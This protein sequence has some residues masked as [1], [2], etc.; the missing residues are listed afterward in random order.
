MVNQSIDFL[1][2][3]KLVKGE[4]DELATIIVKF[5]SYLVCSHPLQVTLPGS[6]AVGS[7]GSLSYDESFAMRPLILGVQK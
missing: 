4:A 5:G 2:G 3:L 1:H 6:S 7:L